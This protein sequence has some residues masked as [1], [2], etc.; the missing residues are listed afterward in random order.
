MPVKMPFRMFATVGGTLVKPH[1]IGKGSLEQIVVAS[2]QT[3]EYVRESKATC[4][5]QSIDIGNVLPAEQQG[6][7]RPCCP[8]RYNREKEFILAD[9]PFARG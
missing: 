2:R 4:G 7:K 3:L 6:F 8:E 9:D 5:I 1:R